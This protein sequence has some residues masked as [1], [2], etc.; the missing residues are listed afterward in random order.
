MRIFPISLLMFGLMPFMANAEWIIQKN[1]I[2]I[3]D[4]LISTSEYETYTGD[5]ALL[6]EENEP[7][8]GYKFVLIDIN[9][10][11]HGDDKEIFDSNK[12]ELKTIKGIYQRAQDD[13]LPNY[14][15]KAFTKL[16][17]KKG[18]HSGHL[19]FEIPADELKEMPSL[20]YKGKGI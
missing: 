3:K 9:V 18:N 19:L 17:I 12:L 2:E 16:K 14:N 10:E 15:F 5:L 13:F 20:L 8:K 6:K 1:N 7:Q 11:K 4:T